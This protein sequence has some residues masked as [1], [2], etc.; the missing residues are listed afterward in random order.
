MMA[1]ALGQEALDARRGE[2]DEDMLGDVE[3]DVTDLVLA[4]NDNRRWS[5]RRLL[6]FEGSLTT[7]DDLDKYFGLGWFQKDFG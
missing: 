2:A 7:Y 5:W 6:F 3:V 4:G 1:C